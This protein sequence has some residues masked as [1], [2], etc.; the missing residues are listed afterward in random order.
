MKGL[1]MRLFTLFIMLL[2]CCGPLTAAENIKPYRLTEND[3]AT[4]LQVQQ[5][6]NRIHTISSDFIQAAPNGDIT[7]GKFCLE[8][9]EKLRMEYDPPTPVLMV[10][11]GN[12]LIYYDRELD[13][14][15]RIRLDSTLVGFLAKDHIAFDNS[16]TITGIEQEDKALRIS[17]IQTRRPKDGTLTLE[18]SEDPLTI[19]NMIVKDSS[20]QTTTV[21]LNNAQFNLPLPQ[22][23]FVFQDPHLGAKGRIKN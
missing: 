22:S 3:K 14:I 11:S 7:S 1:P 12:Y 6:L 18:F 4:L 15:S 2:L 20:G 13:Q 8:R 9:P 21:A 19:R 16:I 10:T 23:L 5:Y 17:L